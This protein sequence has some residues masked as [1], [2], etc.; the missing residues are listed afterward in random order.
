MTAT[1]F[2]LPVQFI[3]NKTFYDLRPR[4]LRDHQPQPSRPVDESLLQEVPMSET[5]LGNTGIPSAG[6]H[7]CVFCLCLSLE[8]GLSFPGGL[9][10][11][12][13]WLPLLC[14]DKVR[15]QKPHWSGALYG[16]LVSMPTLPT[17]SVRSIDHSREFS[18]TQCQL[19]AVLR[20]MSMFPAANT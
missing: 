12:A 1:F 10:Y 14:S 11:I 7:T 5:K 8:G 17:I 13:M 3:T 6:R 9:S 16:W 2:P 18:A 20:I 19:S 15:R 4:D